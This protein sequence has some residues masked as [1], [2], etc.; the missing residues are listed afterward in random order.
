MLHEFVT[1]F[2]VTGIDVLD[3]KIATD[4]TVF[5]ELAVSEISHDALYHVKSQ[6]NVAQVFGNSTDEQGGYQFLLEFYNNFVSVL[7]GL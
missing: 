5:A 1:N 2:F 3:C 4:L 7:Y 6:L